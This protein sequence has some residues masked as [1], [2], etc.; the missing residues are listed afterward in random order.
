M[1]LEARRMTPAPAP[2]PVPNRPR[3]LLRLSLIHI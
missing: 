3:P 2:E 1:S